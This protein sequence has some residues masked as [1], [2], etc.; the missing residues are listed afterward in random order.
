M[1]MGRCQ[2]TEGFASVT[3]NLVPVIEKSHS[4]RHVAIAIGALDVSRRSSVSSRRGQE[5]PLYV[6]LVSYGSSIQALRTKLAKS[7]SSQRDDVLWG[8]FL[9]GIFEVC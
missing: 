2:F 3:A 6:A 5:S 8:T 4:L 9:L 7:G 1:F